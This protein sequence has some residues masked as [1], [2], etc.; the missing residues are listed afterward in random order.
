MAN[1]TYSSP[2]VALVS[3]GLA[4]LAASCD[5]AV[6]KQNEAQVQQ[7]QQQIEQMQ[8]EIAALKAQQ[9]YQ[10]PPPPGSCDRGVMT[11]AARQGGQKYADGDFSRALGYYQDSLAACPGNPRAELNLGRTY[12]ALKDRQQAILHY[13]RAASSTDPGEQAAITEAKAAL[14]RLSRASE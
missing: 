6:Q 7:N 12:E 14:N 9:S 2:L 13:Q 3:L 4:L 11:K 8:H 10:P 5:S 1:R